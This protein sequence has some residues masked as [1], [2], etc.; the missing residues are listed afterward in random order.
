MLKFYEIEGRF[1]TYPEE[2][3]SAAVDYLAG[4]VKVEPALF[5]KYAWS[6]AEQPC[7]RQHPVCCDG[8]W[9][10]RCGP[11]GSRPRTG[12]PWVPVLGA[13]QYVRAI[14]TRHE[15]TLGL[16][17]RRRVAPR[18][19]TRLDD[20]SK[21][22]CTVRD[23]V[24]D[25]VAD[26]APE[27]LPV[28]AGLSRLDDDEALRRL[29]RRRRPREPLGFGLDAV[30]VLATAIT[31]VAVQESVKRMVQPAAD[32]LARGIGTRLRRLF[33]RRS[34]PTVVPA[35]TPEQLAEIRR[36]VLELAEQND[37]DPD[38]ANVLADRVVAR[39]ALGIPDTD[40]SGE[41]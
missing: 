39:L 26:V 4:L 12:G 6:V 8:S 16:G 1:P 28:L 40:Q 33:R 19:V 7:L 29:T 9:P 18:R 31:W 37:F 36:R 25:V 23:V 5:G 15:Q 11:S 21:K 41:R 34:A 30:A 2:V 35:L 24:H 27:E 22:R 3:S 17:R 32:G 38:R 10:I 13:C 20:Q 14:P